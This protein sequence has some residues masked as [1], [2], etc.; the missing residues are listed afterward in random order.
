[1]NKKVFVTVKRHSLVSMPLN[2]RQCRSPT[3]EIEP[4]RQLWPHHLLLPQSR[5]L[6]PI[7]SFPFSLNNFLTPFFS[8]MTA[9]KL[10]NRA[11]T[12]SYTP[13]EA[14]GLFIY[15]SGLFLYLFDFDH[16]WIFWLMHHLDLNFES[17][18]FGICHWIFMLCLFPIC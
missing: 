6:I 1:M 14:S 12:Q 17:Y 5:F 9:L 3:P 7:S 13:R 11:G 2:S 10:S 8:E 18:P 15:F 16:I 4:Q